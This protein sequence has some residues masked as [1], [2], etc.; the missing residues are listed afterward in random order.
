V[1]DLSGV[2]VTELS[3]YYAYVIGKDGHIASFPA[4]GSDSV[5]DATVPELT[6]IP[7]ASAI[8]EPV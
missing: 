6:V 4:F 2:G 5:A 7:T 1:A 8:A 3:E